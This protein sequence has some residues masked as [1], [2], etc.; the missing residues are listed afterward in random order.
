MENNRRLNR[1]RSLPI[2]RFHTENMR[3]LEIRDNNGN[4]IDITDPNRYA[5]HQLTREMFLQNMERRLYGG[6]LLRSE[7]YNINRLVSI[8]DDVNVLE[9]VLGNSLNEGQ[10]YL[11]NVNN[12]MY[13]TLTERRLRSLMAS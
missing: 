10:H 9:D 7:V 6:N 5:Y 8:D 12:N 11:L 2:Y 13:Y 4:I 3:R 1:L